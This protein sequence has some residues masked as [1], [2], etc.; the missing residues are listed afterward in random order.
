MSVVQRIG[1][2]LRSLVESGA[3]IFTPAKD[4][5]PESGVQPFQGEPFDETRNR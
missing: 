3:R 4:D 5:Y 2:F 1:E